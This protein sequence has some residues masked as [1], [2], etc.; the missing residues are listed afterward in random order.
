MV[1]YF[2]LH[3]VIFGLLFGGYD[4]FKP[5]TSVAKYFATCVGKSAMFKSAL[6][7]HSRPTQMMGKSFVHDEMRPSAIKFHSRDQTSQGQQPAQV[8]FT[9]WSPTKA[10]YLHYL[11]DS[12]SVYGAM[13]PAVANHAELRSIR[14]PGLERT[15]ALRADIQWMCQ[16]DPALKAPA[17]GI[18]GQAYTA[19][20]KKLLDVNDVP[21]LVCHYYN[22]YFALSAGGLRIGQHLAHKLLEGKKLQFYTFDPPVESNPA[23]GTSTVNIRSKS[24]VGAS[25]VSTATGGVEHSAQ[26]YHDLTFTSHEAHDSA[27]ADNLYLVNLKDTFRDKIDALAAQ[28]TPAQ[29]L[30]CCTE[31][32]KCFEFNKD[33][34]GYLHGSLV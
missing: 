13:E 31:T 15:N 17:V 16:F 4:C 24:S 23:A 19:Y 34:L 29:R 30:H 33:L 10:D 9:Q 25:T 12:L 6:S 2:I 32:E 21:G 20:I 14:V 8:P 3:L 7:A 26:N 27:P 11:V 18:P 1:A 22:A 5:P 28:W